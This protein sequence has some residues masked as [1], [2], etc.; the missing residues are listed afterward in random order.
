VNTI[1]RMFRSL[2]RQTPTI[3][4][5]GL[6]TLAGG[7]SS[8]TMTPTPAPTLSGTPSF[9][10]IFSVTGTPT[11]GSG[12]SFR[13]TMLYG[14]AFIRIAPTTEAEAVASI[15]EDNIVEVI[16]RNLDGS[17][18]EL[19]RPGRSYGLGWVLAEFLDTDDGAPELLPLTDSVTGLVGASAVVGD[20][21]AA[22]YAVD[23]LVLRDS[24]IVRSGRQIG[25]VP[26]EAVLPVIYR[27]YNTTW[28]FVNY[29]GTLGWVAAFNT[30][31]APSALLVPV[32]PGLLR[33]T[34]VA[35][36]QISP[37]AQRAQIA[38]LR[39]YMAAANEV[40]VGLE[41][42][43]GQVY[44]RE[45]MPCEAPAYVRDYAYTSADTREFPE[46]GRYLPRL[47]VIGSQINASIEPLTQCGV[48]DRSVASRARDVATN[49][50]I[51]IAAT[52]D[53]LLLVEDRIRGDVA[54]TASPPAP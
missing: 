47:D 37:E 19:R 38:R 43:W 54:P 36:E 28:L 18:Y 7:V 29:L 39:A 30:R 51:N 40:A 45:I 35:F 14:S 11:R 33:D 12:Y 17:W 50:K 24:P 2:A 4:L 3:V 1:A 23:N 42:V 46:L 21:I 20:G 13:A 15:F 6:L 25:T 8:Q 27:D 22:T 44:L 52:L 32:A 41:G 31:P 16:G 10:A 48:F 5:C 34:T 9:N 49:A 53:A 26:A